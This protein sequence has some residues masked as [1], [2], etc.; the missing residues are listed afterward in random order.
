MQ[1][2]GSKVA[3]DS[4]VSQ[5]EEVPVTIKVSEDLGQLEPMGPDTD[6]KDGLKVER[7]MWSKLGQRF[8]PVGLQF[9]A[10]ILLWDQHLVIPHVSVPDIR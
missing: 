7:S 2:E 4:K 9:A 8:N 6:V 5:S 3:E 10:H 1:S